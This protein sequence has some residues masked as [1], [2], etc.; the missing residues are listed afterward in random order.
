MTEEIV[1]ETDSGR[2]VTVRHHGDVPDH[3]TRHEEGGTDELDHNDLRNGGQSDAHHTKT[4]SASELSDVSADSDP[5]AHHAQDHASRHHSGAADPLDVGSQPVNSDIDATGQNVD[6]ERFDEMTRQPKP[7]WPRGYNE[8]G[9]VI[10]DF[11]DLSYWGTFAGTMSANTSFPYSGDQSLHAENDP[12]AGDIIG[13]DANLP[14]TIDP[15][16]KSFSIAIY[17][18]APLGNTPTFYL[19]LQDSSSN[20]WARYRTTMRA[21]P[22]WSR[23]DFNIDSWDADEEEFDS[24]DRM[25]IRLPQSSEQW[26]INLDD[27]RMHNRLDQGYVFF[28]FDDSNE[29]QYDYFKN[30]MQPRNYPGIMGTITSIVGD[31]G[32]VTVS[33]LQEMRDNG[34]D[35]ANHADESGSLQFD[36]TDAE[37]EQLVRD[38]KAWLLDNGFREGAQYFVYPQADWDADLIEMLDSYAALGFSGG[39]YGSGHIPTAPHLISTF[40]GEESLSNVEDYLDHI[41]S[42]GGIGGLMIHASLSLSEFESRVQAVEDRDL[43]VINASEI[44]HMMENRRQTAQAA[45]GLARQSTG[46]IGLDVVAGGYTTLSSGTALV[47]TGIS[48]THAFF[49]VYVDPRGGGA[50]DGNEVK[51]AAR[52][53]WDDD[54]DPDGDGTNEGEYVIELVEDGTNVGNPTVGYKVVR[55]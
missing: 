38:A 4:S 43:E 40:D 14:F 8:A 19:W 47:R 20:D 41:E 10:E 17:T 6:A 5:D 30:S 11:E 49:D 52:A 23:L 48:E 51:V 27:L 35:I 25:I 15:R 18:E 50:N 37:A 13:L 34:W 24:V 28:R 54:A 2:T 26:T 32:R 55:W 53:F 22:G 9:E 3:A 31:T 39:R 42:K 45:G 21:S 44:H 36:Y 12:D 1:V 46:A 16:G 33:E 29:V 7:A